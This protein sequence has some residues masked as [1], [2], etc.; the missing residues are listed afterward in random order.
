M[1]PPQTRLP[2]MRELA[3][4][5]LRQLTEGEK[6]WEYHIFGIFVICAYSLPPALRPSSEGG[7]GGGATLQRTEMTDPVGTGID[8]PFREADETM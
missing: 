5:D 2:L 7:E 6:T 1:P 8:G 3:I 4:A